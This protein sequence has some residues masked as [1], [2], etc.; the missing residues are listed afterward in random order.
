[1]TGRI[2]V[3]GGCVLTLG[4]RLPNFAQADVLIEEG[5]IS[6]VGTRLRARDAEVVDATHTIVMPGFVDTHRHVWWSVYR[7]SGELTPDA[8][9]FRPDD[10]YAATYV[11]LLAAVEA[12]ITTV[13]DFSDIQL[14]DPYT[15]AALQAHVDAGLRTVFV[16]AVPE[17]VDVP[18]RW[19]SLR[20]VATGD[21]MLA[22]IAYGSPPH[23]PV[24][25]DAIAGDWARAREL[26]LRIH[27]HAGTAR[28][29]GG[30]LGS[31]RSFLADDVTLV[32]CARLQPDDLDVVASSGAA[33]A[34][35]PASAMATG[36]GPPAVQEF[37]DRG[38][39]PGLA[40]DDDRVAPGDI[41]TQM[42]VL[43][44][45]QHATHFDLKLA[46]KGGLPQLMTTRDVIRHGTVDGAR[47][48]GLG[49]TTGPLEPGLAADLVILR[50][51]RPNIYP[52]NDPI[53]AVVWGMDTS[54]VDWVI[55]DGKILMREGRLEADLAR[56]QRLLADTHRRVALANPLQGQA[57]G[58]GS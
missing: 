7:N 36:L 22:T 47:V 55:A 39:R 26:G 1:M 31:L 17:G 8:S 29:G 34:L 45:I 4:E 27:A 38:I 46:G 53:G 23:L 42:R 35:A 12:G 14:D 48:A 5:R 18:D 52:I 30:D 28:S 50:T 54:N 25:P 57:A 37:I 20:S 21:Q 33:V 41:F 11:G 6:E 15:D 9:R 58:G 43:I 40:V 3:R 2:L 32:H 51:D 49:G 10:V 44:S 56:A 19:R 24:S 16:H 13:V